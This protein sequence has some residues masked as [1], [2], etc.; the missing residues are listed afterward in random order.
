MIHHLRSIHNSSPGNLPATLVILSTG[1]PCN[2][3]PGRFSHRPYRR[4]E[5][6]VYNQLLQPRGT[7]WTGCLV[8]YP[9]PPYA[10]EL[11]F[12]SI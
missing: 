2:R 1:A 6:S 12:L 10:S 3:R 5:I 8:R 9:Y 11:F 7:I 4:K